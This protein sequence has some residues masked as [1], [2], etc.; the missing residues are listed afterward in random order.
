MALEIAQ[1]CCQVRNKRGGK[2]RPPLAGA[3]G[4]LASSPFPAAAGGKQG[5]CNNP[6]RLP[7]NHSH[8][9]VVMLH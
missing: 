1:G 4:V 7:W 9:S 2:G 3:R 8:L 5:R 6:G